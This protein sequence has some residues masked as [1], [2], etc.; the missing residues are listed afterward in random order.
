MTIAA[1]PP[2]LASPPKCEVCGVRMAYVGT[3]PAI[4]SKAGA[5]GFPLLWMQ[6][7][8]D[9]TALTPPGKPDA[10]QGH[11]K[12]ATRDQSSSRRV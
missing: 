6:R 2:V 12:V 9:R 10:R 11:G 4:L 7:S 3:L 5:E 1:H 8:Q